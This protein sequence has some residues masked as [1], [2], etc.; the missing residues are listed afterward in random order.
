[1]EKFN[2]SKSMCDDCIRRKDCT[3]VVDEPDT[4]V[5]KQCVYHSTQAEIN[6]FPDLPIECDASEVDIY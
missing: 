5:I 1:M 3:I 4:T 2:L 6:K